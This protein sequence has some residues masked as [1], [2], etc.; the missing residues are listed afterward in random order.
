MSESSKI[1]IEPEEI[2]SF[3]KQETKFKEAYQ[4]ILFQKT[5]TRVALEQGVTV[6]TDEIQDV[7]DRQRRERRLEKASDTVAWLAEQMITPYDWEAGIRN[8]LLAQKL[9]LEMF[10]K[11]VEKFFNQNRLEF[12]QVILYR[13]IVAS[14]K[15][16]QELYFQIEEKE[17]SFYAAAHQYDIDEN[18]RL[19]CGYEGK[20]YRWSLEADIA[21]IVFSTSPQQ[22]IGPIK[23]EQGYH[24][25]F[26][27]D[28]IPAELTA[29]RYQ[30]ILNY[31]FQQ[32]LNSEV[33]SMLNS[34]LA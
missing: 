12:E 30:E 25:I 1:N 2:V 28:L 20:V 31:M 14:N 13:M 19:K 16:A 22:L 10:G 8:T 17:V 4:K 11:E 5:I 15:L 32:W 33:D 6:T 18:R 24:L 9:A 7:A 23:T 29:D 3:L 27:E 21:A 26:V 34:E